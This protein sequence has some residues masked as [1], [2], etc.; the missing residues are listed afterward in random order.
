MLLHLYCYHILAKKIAWFD[1][2]S[3]YNWGRITKTLVYVLTFWIS[4]FLSQKSLSTGVWPWSPS[5]YDRG[6]VQ[7]F[8]D[9]LLGQLDMQSGCWSRCKI[10]SLDL[11]TWSWIRVFESGSRILLFFFRI[12]THVLIK[13]DYDI[14]EGIDVTYLLTVYVLQ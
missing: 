14:V 8:R 13:T 1:F 2:L 9:Y 6:T 11:V 5:V 7:I 12:Y 3:I 4:K 10:E